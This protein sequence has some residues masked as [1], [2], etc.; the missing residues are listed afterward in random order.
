MPKYKGV[1]KRG[2]KYY[3]RIYRKGK[4]KESNGYKTAVEGNRFI[5]HIVSIKQ[6]P[7]CDTVFV[8]FIVFSED[9]ILVL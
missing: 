5:S 8:S 3:Y 9:I 7:F 2:N 1:L 6:P 4:Q